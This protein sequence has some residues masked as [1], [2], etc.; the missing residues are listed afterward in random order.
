LALLLREEDVRALLPM[1]TAVDL[2][3]GVFRAQARG[4]AENGSR[5]RVSFPGGTLNY[6]GGAVPERQAAGIKVYPATK[7]G[8]NFVVL[9]FDTGSAELLAIMEADWLGRIRTGAASGV[10]TRYLAREDAKVLG[11]I[12]AGGQAETQIEAV[13]AVRAIESVK[14]FSPT[15]EKRDLLAQRVRDRLGLRV[16]AVA[17]PETAVRGSDIVTTITSASQPVLDGAWVNEG[18][19]VNAAGNNRANHREIDATVVRR[20]A[21]IATDSVEQARIECGDLILAAREGTLNWDQVVPLCE[22]VTGRVNGP[23]DGSEV[24]LFESQGVAIEDVMVARYVYDEAVRAGR[25]QRVR[26]GGEA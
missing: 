17:S 12:G 2:V 13:A 20:S 16:D 23:R 4:G 6:M 15:P 7:A 8:V 19:H 22:I 10:A 24:T 21:V 25:G 11:V 1:R 26:F 5:R 14:V 9:L 3:E 18:S